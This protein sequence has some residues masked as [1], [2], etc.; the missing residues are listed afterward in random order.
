M[1]RDAQELAGFGILE[2][3]RTQ[4]EGREQDIMRPEFPWDGFEIEME[5]KKDEGEAA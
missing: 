4:R 2:L 1:F 3:N 5:K